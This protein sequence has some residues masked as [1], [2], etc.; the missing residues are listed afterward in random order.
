MTLIFLR[1]CRL[2]NYGEANLIMHCP[3]SLS[4]KDI[5]MIYLNPLQ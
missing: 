3:V 1:C 5:Y 4:A 2:E